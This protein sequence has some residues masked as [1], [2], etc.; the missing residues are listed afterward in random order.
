MPKAKL[1]SSA[2]V[3]GDQFESEHRWNYEKVAFFIG[4]FQTIEANIPLL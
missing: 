1:S 3:Y 2:A 4:A